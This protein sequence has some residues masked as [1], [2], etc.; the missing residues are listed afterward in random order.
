MGLSAPGLTAGAIIFV[1]DQRWADSNV[2][3][4]IAD[5]IKAPAQAANKR[6]ENAALILF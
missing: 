1:G 4:V 5:L 6:I 3:A 2:I